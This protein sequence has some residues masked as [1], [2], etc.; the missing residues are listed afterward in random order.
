M[1]S[2]SRIGAHQGHRSSLLAPLKNVDRNK[3]R[4]KLIR[5]LL[6]FGLL[7]RTSVGV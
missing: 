4:L 7:T 3:L 2:V 1:T 6:G 5:S